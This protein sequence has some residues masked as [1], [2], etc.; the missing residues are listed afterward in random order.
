MVKSNKTGEI[1]SNSNLFDFLF[2]KKLGK[3]ISICIE[4]MFYKL[5]MHTRL[6]TNL[7]ESLILKKIISSDK[8]LC[9]FRKKIL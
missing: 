3:Q 8:G 9:I 5:I 4:N 7:L 2:K 6:N 1:F